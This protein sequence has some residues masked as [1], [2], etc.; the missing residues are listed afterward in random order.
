M[1]NTYAMT[2]LL[3]IFGLLGNTDMA[4]DMA[5]VQGATLALFY[6][7]SA[8]AR[9]LILN[10]ASSVSV[11]SVVRFRLLLILPL[12]AIAYWLCVG[13]T[14]MESMLASILILR[15]GVEWL[16]EAYLSE[17][18]RLDISKTSKRY[19]FIQT[20]LFFFALVWMLSELT[21]VEKNGHFFI[22]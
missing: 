18:E 20:A 10:Q 1:A 21:L 2:G 17:I 16:D 22:V 13:S 7:F 3:I 12:S 15:R 8:N 4:A 14:G 11:E 5:I 19:L 6:A 9:S